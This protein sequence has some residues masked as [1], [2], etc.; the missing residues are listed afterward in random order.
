MKRLL[1]HLASELNPISEDKL[2]ERYDE[3]LDCEGTV[4]AG[5]LDFYPSKILSEC[6]PIAYRCGFSDWL[7]GERDN[8]TEFNGEYYDLV[9]FE[10]VVDELVD[11]IESEI[12]DLGDKLADANEAEASAIQLSI[13]DLEKDITTIRKESNT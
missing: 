4:R 1:D 12:S 2:H 8:L 11:E 9:Q 7:D 13:D 5:G 3:A 10:D 6:D